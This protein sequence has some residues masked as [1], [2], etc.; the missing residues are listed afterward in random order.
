MKPDN[1]TLAE[2]FLCVTCIFREEPLFCDR[3]QKLKYGCA[4]IEKRNTSID[5]VL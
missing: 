4:I 5:G 2:T 3:M 1:T